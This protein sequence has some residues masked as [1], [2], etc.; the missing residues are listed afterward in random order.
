[1]MTGVRGL[2]IPAFSLAIASRLSPKI[3]VWSR[4][5][6]VMIE[7]TGETMFVASNRPPKPVSKTAKSTFS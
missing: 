6:E 7:R 5:I 2:M 1:M 3:S 4:L